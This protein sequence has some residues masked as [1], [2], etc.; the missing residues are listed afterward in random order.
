MLFRRMTTTTTMMESPS[1]LP[2]ITKR[3]LRRVGIPLRFEDNVRDWM[4][5][6]W[7][8]MQLYLWNHEEFKKYERLKEIRKDRLF[9][10]DGA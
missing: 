3:E 7:L 5:R 10:E 1:S 2:R 4:R 9:E 8:E 6:G